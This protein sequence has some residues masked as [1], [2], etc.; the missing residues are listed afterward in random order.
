MA[1]IALQPQGSCVTF[2]SRHAP[3]S[4]SLKLKQGSTKHHR[5]GRTDWNYLPK[6]SILSVGPSYIF[7]AKI[8]SFRISAFKDSSQ[9]YQKGGRPNGLKVPKAY[10]RLEEGG[11]TKSESPKAQN[12]PLSYGSEANDDLA[13]ENIPT[14]T[15]IH[16]L[17]KKWLTILRT[18]P[19]SEEVKEILGE[20]SQGALPET[21]DGSQSI[22]R[23]KI[24][25]VAWT[26]FLALD[27]TVK[28]PLLIFVPFYLAVNVRYGAKVSKELTPLWVVG[29]LIVALYVVIIRKL[30]SLYV[31]SFKQTVKVI[32]NFPSYCILAYS[33]VFGGKI[34]EDFQTLIL[35]SILGIKGIDY[36]EQSRRKLK[37]LK[38]WIVEK[39]LDFVESIWP[40]YCRTIRFLK[41]ANLI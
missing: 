4:K 25:K 7:G 33:Y 18:Q 12:V 23:G 6:R 13:N 29:P 31:F 1:L 2:S 38:E 19:A 16:K 40:Y 10:V 11:E 21:L 20:P 22:E 26:H 32:K 3:W 24:L 30:W 27:E 17:F 36:K 34:K 15:A 14:S 28:I 41:R 39:Y 37:E 5:I 35:Q 8:Q 9:H